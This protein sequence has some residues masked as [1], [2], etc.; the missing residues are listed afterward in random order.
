MEKQATAEK[1]AGFA[2]TEQGRAVGWL[3][4]VDAARK[5]LSFYNRCGYIREA[6]FKD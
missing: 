3:G 1:E 2:A 6:P 4:L 5:Q